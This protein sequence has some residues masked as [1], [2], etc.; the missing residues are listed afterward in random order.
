MMCYSALLRGINVSGQKRMKMEDLKNVFLS[1]GYTDVTTY[2]Q[3][4]NVL[5]Y[6]EEENRQL[7]IEKIEGEIEKVFGFQVP[8]IIRTTDELKNILKSNPFLK[9]SVEAEK[10]YV[11]FL[12][13]LPSEEAVEKLLAYKSESDQLLVQGQ[14]VYI[15]CENGYGN[16]KL[17]NS[18]L[19]K[20]LKIISTTRNLKTIHK[21]IEMSDHLNDRNEI[22]EGERNGK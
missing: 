5:F 8:V 17:S 19:E 4:G 20:K 7:M 22:P 2:I 13:Q 3:S 11:S 21:M 9:L 1:L 6:C 14:E 15:C 12:A 10:L 16:T 18:F